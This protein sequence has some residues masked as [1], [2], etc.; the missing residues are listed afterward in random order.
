MR[1]NEFRANSGVSLVKDFLTKIFGTILLPAISKF[2][3]M[4]FDYLCSKKKYLLYNLIARNLKVKYRRSFFGVLW[5]LVVPLLMTLVYY[6]VFDMFLKIGIPNYTL[7]VITGVLPW[8]FVSQTIVESTETL[9][10]SAGLLNKIPIPTQVFP[11]TAACTNFITYLAALPV[12]LI[13]HLLKIGVPGVPFVIAYIFYSIL[14][15]L[16]IYSIGLITSILF[17]AFRDLRHA[18]VILVQ[19]LMYGT[20]VLYPDTMVPSGFKWVLFVNPLGF[21]FGGFHRSLYGG[22]LPSENYI[23]VPLI[24]AVGLV[25]FSSYFHKKFSPKIIEMI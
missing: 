4:G 6:I 9:Y 23:Y 13:V 1:K 8:A 3:P 5:T 16:I 18:M 7:F 2:Q 17:I 12:I 20:P 24:W 21:L 11:L 25:L 10:V 22:S 15:F 19:V 14:M